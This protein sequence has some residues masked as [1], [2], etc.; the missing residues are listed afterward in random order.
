MRESSPLF[1]CFVVVLWL[2]R[3]EGAEGKQPPK[4]KGL[5]TRM[6]RTS[7]IDR[8]PGRRCRKSPGLFVLSLSHSLECSSSGLSIHARTSAS[9]TPTRL[10]SRPSRV[11]LELYHN[12][13][14]RGTHETR[15]SEAPQ[16][17]LNLP[18]PFLKLERTCKSEGWF[19]QCADDRQSQS[20]LFQRETRNPQSERQHRNH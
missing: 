19:D 1:V 14:P 9:L 5:T 7:H 20:L 17:I 3:C 15:Q 4:T 8:P 13:L 16:K 10:T 11:I 18:L 12:G 2:G 6:R